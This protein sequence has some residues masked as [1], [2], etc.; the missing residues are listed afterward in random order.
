MKY[1]V[2]LLVMVGFCSLSAQALTIYTDMAAGDNPFVLFK[3]KPSFTPSTDAASIDT[4]TQKTT[5]TV[6]GRCSGGLMTVSGAMRLYAFG[7]FGAVHTY[8]DLNS[9]TWSTSAAAPP[10]TTNNSGFCV[11]NNMLY[12]FGSYGNHKHVMVY[13]P[14]TNAWTTKS[15]IPDTY[16]NS[17]WYTQAC[18]PIGGGKILIAGGSNAKYGTPCATA[19]VYDTASDSYTLAASMPAAR[20]YATPAFFN[21]MAYVIGGYST[22]SSVYIYN[23]NTNTWSTGPS[24]PSAKF[25]RC[26]AAVNGNG[27]FYYGG[28][29]YNGNARS[30]Y[31]L[32]Y[33]SETA[34]QTD[35]S[36]PST[37]TNA[38]VSPMAGGWDY[39]L[40]IAGGGDSG[41]TYGDCYIGTGHSVGF[42]TSNYS[43][44]LPEQTGLT[45]I[46]PNPFRD[47]LRI[48]YKL[49]SSDHMKMV[50]IS[51]YDLRG[52]KVATVVNENRAE[53]QHAFFF[54]DK[55][56][57]GV[58]IIKMSVNN[59]LV[60][61]KKVVSL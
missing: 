13:N 30:V 49:I 42:E 33:G 44:F 51:L 32:F 28:S 23:P 55:L 52:K 16:C 50:N 26:G 9:N 41:S 3:E 18:A 4:W 40:I 15:D 37:Y 5:G 1:L 53:G 56:T 47:Y 60:G 35:T 58:Y 31:A 45:T 2:V 34:W 7:G 17:Y 36:L 48:G 10:Y 6:G 25:S 22:E 12:I 20:Y 43:R 29:N 38:G 14:T 19:V 61:T 54:K 24:V 46:G 11:Y 27:L 57:A 21:G 39:N 8:Y 59:T